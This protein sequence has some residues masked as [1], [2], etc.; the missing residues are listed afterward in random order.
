MAQAVVAGPPPRTPGFAPGSVYVG[1]VVDRA[2][3]VQVFIRVLRYSPVNI[4]PPRFHTYVSRVGVFN[5]VLASTTMLF[6]YCT[7]LFDIYVNYGGSSG[8]SMPVFAVEN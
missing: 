5:L 1:F 2:A 7:V 6:G 4:I 8:H 3:L